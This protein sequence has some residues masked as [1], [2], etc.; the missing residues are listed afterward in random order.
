MVTLLA[1][2]TAAPARAQF[3]AGVSDLDA[4][5]HGDAGADVRDAGAP[6]DAE[7]PDAEAPDAEAPE[8]TEVPS[9]SASA[10]ES[11]D[12][13][14]DDADAAADD[15]EDATQM[16]GSSPDDADEELSDDELEDDDDLVYSATGTVDVRIHEPRRTA[17]SDYQLS[18]EAFRA[19]PRPSAES[20]LSL[21]PG[22]FLVNHAGTYHAS[23]IYTRGF[24]AGEGQDV[25]MLVDGIPVNEVSNV[26][27]HGYADTNFLIPEVVHSISFTQGP[28]APVQGD[29]SVAGTAAYTL[30]P[31]QRG[32]TL[33]AQYGS[34]ESRRLLLMWAPVQ[35]RQGTFVGV[36]L[37]DSAG[38]G[39]NR[40]STSASVNGRLEL[41]VARDLVFHVFGAA[42]LANFASAGVVRSD[43]VARRRLACAD[44]PDAQFFCTEDPNQGGA[45]Q[46]AMLSTGLSWRGAHA[47]FDAL[48]YGGYRGLRIREDFSGMIHDARGD[49]QDEQYE[50]GTV[51]LTG[52]YQFEG[53][54]LGRTQQFEIGVSAR[55][56]SGITRQLRM[57]AGTGI[58]YA[59][60]FDDDIHITRIGAHVGGDLSVADWLSLRLG[61]RADV[62]A[63]D[64]RNHAFPS[65]DRDGARLPEQATD[66][67]GVALQPRGTLRVRLA[68]F[69]PVNDRGVSTLEW[70]TSAGVG[71]RSSDAARLSEGEFAPF[72]QVFSS[73]TGLVLQSH[74][75]VDL[76][77]DARAVAFQT[78]VDHDLVFDPVAGRNVDQG[79]T[80][81]LGASAYLNI[82]AWQWLAVAAS[83]SWTEAFIGAPGILDFVTP[84]RLPY[85]PRW[86]GRLD[87]AGTRSITIEGESVAFTIGVGVGWLG[88]RP[89]PLGL[90][91]PQ[92]LLLDAQIAA[93]WRGIELAV[94]AQNLTDTRWQSSV[95]NYSSWFDASLPQSRT[96]EF[97]Y[98]AGPPLSITGR[99][100]VRFDETAIF[101]GGAAT[102]PV[103]P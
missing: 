95:F 3:D 69:A 14:E 11:E 67:V 68:E 17:A 9:E 54:V 50:V 10:S 57:R 73:E 55:H 44:T 79:A 49:G 15:D 36:D 85:V 22:V 53:D 94:L 80:S 101:A 31:T 78:H 27:Q 28:Y 61:A 24:E 87:A 103:T 71:T 39:A 8:A 20:L 74:L 60:T 19:V 84:T 76:A 86:V 48:L 72:A 83:F 51:G 56:D 34:F 26:H 77:V 35:A 43:D 32:V 82:R 45:S 63:F 4:A 75:D 41:E 89:I 62:F 5:D 46:R 37:R 42:Q 38:F 66:A 13:V 18:V 90:V 93:E 96:P 25:E 23:S 30:G 47:R 40:S 29:F 100:T 64:V 33:R 59:A 58:P 88:E 92:V 52:R 1:C 65:I 91:A 12:E 16:A 70:Q 98:A 99:L 6:I 21:A 102:A 97:M 81:R 7:A 2:A